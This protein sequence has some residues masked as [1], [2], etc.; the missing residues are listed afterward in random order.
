MKILIVIPAYNEE[1]SIYETVVEYISVFPEATIA[2]ID[3]NSSDN[4]K[5]EALRALRHDQDHYLHEKKQGKGH[6]VIQGL[7]RIS[8]DIYIMTDGDITYP[9]EDARKCLNT[10]LE[11][12]CDMVSGDRLSSGAYASQNKRAG[13]DLGNA[14]FSHAISFI[15]ARKYND[16]FSGLRVM[17]RPFVRMLSLRSTGFQLE[18]ELSLFSAYLSADVIEQPTEYRSRIEGSESKLSSFRDGFKIMKFI[19][20]NWVFYKPIQVLSLIFTLSFIFGLLSIFRP[21]AEL[22]STG[23]LSAPYSGSFM[24]GGLFASLCGISFMI[25]MIMQV[26]VSSS[27][28]RDISLFRETKRLWNK[29]LDSL[30]TK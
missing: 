4:T 1:Q 8:A 26:I 30:N 22:L 15:A 20:A 27:Q 5:A 9:A 25:G 19:L 10:M 29:K 12:R 23:S 14:F 13:H 7:S 18:S 3:N 16:V 21:A 2:V 6:A 28:R 11:T 17:S 24:L